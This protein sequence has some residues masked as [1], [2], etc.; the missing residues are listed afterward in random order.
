[1]K[2]ST[3]VVAWSLRAAAACAVALGASCTPQT[4]CDY[5]DKEVVDSLHPV[6][7][8][9]AYCWQGYDQFGLFVF[10]FERASQA[11]P[12]FI[13]QPPTSLEPAGAELASTWTLGSLQTSSGTIA[14]LD[15]PGLGGAIDVQV[16]RT[17]MLLGTVTSASGGSALRRAV[18]RGFGFETQE[19][20]CRGS[21]SR[22]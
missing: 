13:V 22:P 4:E 6:E 18:C 12:V 11:N 15:V 2:Q 17:S 19:K 21:A 7:D 8:D 20:A 16:N 3:R 14:A 9:V 1:M 5:I 10:R